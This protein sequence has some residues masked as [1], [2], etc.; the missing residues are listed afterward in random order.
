MSTTM[1][2]EGTV[3]NS[4]AKAVGTV[5]TAP[6][7]RKLPPKRT[8]GDNANP[9]FYVV[10]ILLVV[11]ALGPIVLML[12]TSLKLKVDI[13]SST[14]GWL[15]VPTMANYETVL[16]NVLWYTPEHVS[17][18]NPTFGRAL[19]NSLIVATISTGL[20]LLIGCMAA[21]A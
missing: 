8:S 7:A 12:T 4:L 20:T 6:P 9:L 21:Y 16:C 14:S 13:F 1:T 3:P 10:I 19:G 5:P 11:M 18:C 2:P 15:F 17:Y